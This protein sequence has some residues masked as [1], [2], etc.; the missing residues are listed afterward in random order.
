MS[1]NTLKR[2]IPRSLLSNFL[3][4]KFT[5]MLKS[6]TILPLLIYFQGTSSQLKS[7]FPSMKASSCYLGTKNPKSHWIWLLSP[8]QIDFAPSSLKLSTLKVLSSD[9]DCHFASLWSTLLKSISK[10]SKKLLRSWEWIPLSQ[11]LML[12]GSK[13]TLLEWF[14]R[15]IWL[16]S[17]SISRHRR[18]SKS[19][20]RSGL[21]LIKIVRW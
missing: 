2:K 11:G 20:K 10:L 8:S 6:I 12:H 7:L 1:S 16:A 13:G 5:Q 19:C 14:S 21:R 17:T 3:R 4:T 9:S 15:M 18:V